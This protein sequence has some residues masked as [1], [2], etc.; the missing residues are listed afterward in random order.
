MSVFPI[1][2][3]GGAKI[4]LLRK[5][6]GWT[7]AELAK[8][9]FVSAKYISQIETDHPKNISPDILQNIIT[10]LEASYGEQRSILESYGY[11]PI[12]V[13]P[14]EEEIA[15]ACQTFHKELANLTMP[16]YLIDCQTLL[17]TWNHYLPLLLGTETAVLEMLKG[18]HFIHL[19]THP[20]VNLLGK[21]VNRDEFL[22]MNMHSLKD[23]IWPYLQTDWAEE[24]IN[25]YQHLGAWDRLYVGSEIP[26]RTRTTLRYQPDETTTVAVK[27]IQE[28]FIRDDRFRVVY[29]MPA[30]VEAYHLFEQW[31]EQGDDS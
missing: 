12:V 6:K 31:Q 1:S 11:H 24:V 29:I 16:A 9:A 20:Q 21:M 22:Q 28:A 2:L 27:V 18:H 5:R 19:F 4:R 13:A 26:A 10:A 14:N 15:W 25:T 7:Q 23:L 30:N 3:T 8:K 17:H